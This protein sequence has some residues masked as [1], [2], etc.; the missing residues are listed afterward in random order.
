MNEHIV[1]LATDAHAIG[2]CVNDYSPQAVAEHTQAPIMSLKR[3]LHNL[4]LLS[5]HKWP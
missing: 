3:R 5:L 1:V 4:T 2:V